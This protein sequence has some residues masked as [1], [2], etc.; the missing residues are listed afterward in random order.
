M[1]EKKK[2]SFSQVEGSDEE[3]FAGFDDVQASNEC[4]LIYFLCDY[5]FFHTDI[6]VSIF[7][8]QGQN[9]DTGIKKLRETS[10]IKSNKTPKE[11]AKKNYNDP[12]FRKPFQFNWKREVVSKNYNILLMICKIIYSFIFQ[13][14][15]AVQNEKATQK[16]R[17]DVYYITPAGKKLRT[18]QEILNN[19]D[20]N[21]DL[22][23]ENFTFAKDPVGGTSEQEIIRYF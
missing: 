5:N 13:V 15:R 14:Y 7:A 19:L 4:K 16:E 8:D 12:I 10:P 17:G 6:F 20:K 2:R 18:K 22:T 11:L 3:D 9:L 1:S 21:M 23:I